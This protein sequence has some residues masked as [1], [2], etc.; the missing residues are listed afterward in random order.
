MKFCEEIYDQCKDAEF[1]GKLL[2]DIYKNGRSFCEA[3]DFHVIESNYQCFQ[4]DPTPFSRA[5]Y[6]VVAMPPRHLAA[7][8]YL[9][10]LVSIFICSNF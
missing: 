4:F 7:I 6:L 3:Q 9:S 2:G 1:R 5:A 10:M 8:A